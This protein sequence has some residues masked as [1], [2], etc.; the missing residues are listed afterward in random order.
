MLNGFQ[1]SVSCIAR[2]NLALPLTFKHSYGS[3][4]DWHLM[5]SSNN[6]YPTWAQVSTMNDE[7]LEFKNYS[8]GY[9]AKE[10]A[11][12]FVTTIDECVSEAASHRNMCYQSI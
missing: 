10:M 4:T 5:P 12:I 3:S 7:N 2:A 1:S 8:S 9:K 6:L 11:E